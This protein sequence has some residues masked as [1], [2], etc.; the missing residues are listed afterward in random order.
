LKTKDSTSDKSTSA[1]INW[2]DFDKV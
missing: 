2:S 1:G